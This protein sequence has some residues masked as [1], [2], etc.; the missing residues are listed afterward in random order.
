M[1]ALTRRET[2]GLFPDLFDW[3]E[4]PFAVLRPFSAQPIRM[5]D[6]IEDGHYVVRAELPGIDPEKQ[7]EVTV[8]KGIL[9]IHAERHEEVETKHRS[10]FT[11]GAFSRHVPLP[12]SA[13]ET[14]VEA[15]YEKGI[16]TVK[17]ALREK[18]NVAGR[19]IP[20]TSPERM[21]KTV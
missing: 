4:S 9:T 3:L 13:D 12:A 6:Y 20:V 1:S 19:Q 11:Y 14:D 2:R 10:E 8:S 15:T 7:I 18:E 17:V 5:E 16:L 21:K